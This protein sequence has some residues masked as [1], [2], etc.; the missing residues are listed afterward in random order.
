[1][2]LETTVSLARIAF[3][4]MFLVKM[5]FTF[6]GRRLIWATRYPDGIQTDRV[7]A[8][9]LLLQT[10]L[11]LLFTVGLFTEVVALFQAVLFLYLLR[12]A[13]IYGLEDTVFHIL[14]VY[15]VLA[16]AG[17]AWSLDVILGVQF[18]GR[19]PEGTLIAELA[20]ATVFGLIFFSSGVNK[21]LSPMWRKGLGAYYF[22]SLPLHRR[23]SVKPFIGREWLMRSLNYLT[24]AFQ[25]GM[26]PALF[27]NA[28]PLGLVFWVLVFGFAVI[29][30]TVFVFTW[31]GESLALGFLIILWLLFEL[32]F[33]G[34]GWRWVDDIN[35]LSGPLEFIVVGLLLVTIVAVIWTAVLP[36]VV[37]RFANGLIANV[38]VAMR[39]VARYVWGYVPVE[40]FNEKHTQGPVLYR[41][42]STSDEE[43]WHEGFRIFGESGMAGPDRNWRPTFVEVTQYRVAEACMELDR[44]GEIRTEER[45]IFIFRLAEH[46]AAEF[47]RVHQLQPSKIVFKTLQ[48]LPPS[49]YVGD[50]DRWYSDKSWKESFEVIFS[51]GHAAAVLPLSRTILEGPTGRN[52]ERLSY[53]FNPHG[54]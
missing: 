30:S 8:S 52:L 29:L 48:V 17:S 14:S 45:R 1:M 38:N 11:L 4:L 47:R 10:A 43:S 39:Y 32:R 24:L 7:L 18:W 46:V 54:R 25:L 21:L 37:P 51:D 26:L 40:L 15:F 9:V 12:R 34:M 44:Y 13:A 31:L 36:H 20:L 49:R 16:G 19:F 50:D 23:L 22:F 28:L 53:D 5:Y 3:G 35:S 2:S 41:V 42:F 33:Q 6:Q 27:L